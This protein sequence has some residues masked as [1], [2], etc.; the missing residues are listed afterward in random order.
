MPDLQ[1]EQPF[2]PRE[3][4]RPLWTRRWLIAVVVVAATAAAY[5]YS[6]SQPERFTSS[7]QVFLFTSQVEAVLSEGAAPVSDDRTTQ[8]IAAL[9]TSRTVAAEAARRIGYRGDPDSLLASMKVLPA[10]GADYVTIEAEWGSA[11]GAARLA[12]A[13]AGAFIAT[14]SE[15]ARDQARDARTLAESRLER[16][17]ADGGNRVAVR[18]LRA[19]IQRLKVIE[20]LPAGAAEQ[21]DRA[22]APTVPSAPKPRRN[23]LFAFVMAL[24]LMAALAYGLE[25]FDRR[26]KRL[27]DVEPLYGAPVIGVVPRV[28]D[29]DSRHG[30]D[31]D[32]PEMGR[33]AFRMLR[34]NLQLADLDN[35]LSTLLVTSAVPE[36]GKSTV[37]RNLALAYR[38]S[39][40]RVAVAELDLRRPR[41]A[42]LFG[43]RSEPGLTDVL[44]SGNGVTA[45][46]QPVAAGMAAVAEHRAVGGMSGHNGAGATLGTAG[47][48]SVLTSGAI[49][50][51]PPAVL[52]AQR[53]HAVL[54]ELESDHDIVLID[55]APILAVGDTLPLLSAVDGVLVVTRAHSTTRDAAR[56]LSDAVA[57]APGVRVVGVVV[58]DMREQQAGYLSYY[59]YE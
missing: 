5:L 14:R 20:T 45:A 21:V 17:Q 40:L 39:G 58:N 23:A 9:L 26:I 30:K 10:S 38:E 8:T 4:L 37:V 13:F 12:N 25:R 33:E 55:S 29:I 27:D 18:S 36:E 42:H 7:T 3:Y 47:T 46:L 2:H 56:R 44:V 31:L 11:R 59:R 16:L 32:L 48:L 50:P 6:D 53:L 41:L 57:R 51:N 15:A 28:R 24:V 34:S 54:S 22:E 35:G 1:T 43:L 52:A 49:P 19:R